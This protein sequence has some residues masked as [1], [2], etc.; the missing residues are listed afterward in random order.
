MKI[1]GKVDKIKELAGCGGDIKV[2]VDGDK[3]YRTDTRID[4]DE[5]RRLIGKRV[6]LEYTLEKI[7]MF[8]WIFEKVLFVSYSVPREYNRIE[9]ISQIEENGR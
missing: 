4:K 3:F 8:A 1:K 2:I 7:S 6:E 5:F 9:K